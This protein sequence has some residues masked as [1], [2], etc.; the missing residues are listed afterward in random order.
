MVD[1][2][3]VYCPGDLVCRAKAVQYDVCA[4]RGERAGD[5]KADPAG[6]AGHQ[7][8][9]IHEC[10]R[11]ASGWRLELDIHVPNLLAAATSGL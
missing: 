8:D 11:F 3:R 1:L 9:L 7:R 5:A 4:R 2:Y 6:R 10:F